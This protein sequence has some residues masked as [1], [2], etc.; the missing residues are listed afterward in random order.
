VQFLS[1]LLNNLEYRALFSYALINNDGSDTPYFVQLSLV[2]LL[3][4]VTHSPCPYFTVMPATAR[5]L[6]LQ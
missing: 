6:T 1:N 5:L 4:D 3:S 2:L